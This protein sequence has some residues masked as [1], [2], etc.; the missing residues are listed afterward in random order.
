M[1]VQL[2]RTILLLLLVSNTAFAQN[3]ATKDASRFNIALL[4]VLDEYERT[5]PFSEQKDRRDFLDLFSNEGTACVYNDFLG[6]GSYQAMISP[7]EYSDYARYDGSF[8][9]R[10]S[11]SD[12]K[13]EGDI[14]Y[15]NGK[16]HR[17]ISFSKY[18]MIIDASVYSGGEGGVLFDSS[19]AYESSPDFRLVMDVSYDPETGECRIDSIQPAAEKP[20]TP[21]DDAQFSVIIKSE[22]KYDED[23]TSRGER[24]KFNEFGQTISYWNDIDVDNGDVK[25]MSREVTQGDHY[26]ILAVD[27]KPIRFR[28]KIYG[29][30]SLGNAFKIESSVPGLESSS[31]AMNFGVDLGFEKALAKRFRLGIYAGVGLSMGKIGLSVP[32]VNYTLR[33]VFPNREYSFSAKENLSIMDLLV[34]VY[35]ES[36][37][38]ITKRLV[39]DIDLGAR[40]YFNMKTTLSPY[41]VDGIVGGASINTSYSAFKDPAD[42]TRKAYDPVLFG[43]VELDFAI[44]K[45]LLFVYVS[46]G[47]EHGLMP[48]YDSGL[49]TYLQ[50]S[51]DVY[52]IYY[53]PVSN[54]DIPMRSLIGS[55]RYLRKAGWVAAGIKIKF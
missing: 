36:E 13:K 20:R 10:S 25:L 3:V 43:N 27:Y 41:E 38:E 26:N 15:S 2:V 46:G 35:L 55:V 52:P 7:R 6:T 14:T 8:L 30:L 9:I 53:S 45:K 16:L 18:V 42:Y 32:K 22:K 5:C 44:V 4:G 37:I 1:K 48:V 12:V 17:R 23:L 50:E 34:P 31:S 11:I 33:Y 49:R 40:F 28:G 54:S 21:L 24:L 29:N 51:S 39:L 47:Y 19:Q